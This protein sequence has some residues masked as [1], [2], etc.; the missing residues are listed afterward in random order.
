MKTR[1]V[2]RTKARDYLKRAGECKNSM[3]RSFD[4][5]D[6]NACIIMAIHS[7]ISTA[8]A[9]C[10]SELGLR[11]ASDRHADVVRLLMGINPDDEEIKRNVKRLGRLLDIKTDAEYGE[12]L[13]TRGN[14]EEAIKH[15]ERLFEF[16][17]TIF[18]K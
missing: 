6:W 3:L 12:K 13:F 4:A 15:A 8:D 9:V 10:V 18:D 7:A 5:G 16:A 14:A 11:S 17:K 2:D 1:P